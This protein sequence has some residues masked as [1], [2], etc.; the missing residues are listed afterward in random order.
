VI[1]GGYTLDLYCDS[2]A[3]RHKN[4][5]IDTGDIRRG[6]FP[7]Q[8]VGEFGS[9]CRRAARSAGWL[10]KRDGRAVCP[11]CREE[12]MRKDSEVRSGT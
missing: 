10:L 4:G 8:F 3:S 11:E 7:I 9:Q 2:G 6:R 1:I 5:W 12:K